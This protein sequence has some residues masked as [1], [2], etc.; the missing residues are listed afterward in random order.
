MRFAGQQS[1]GDSQRAVCVNGPA[2]PGEQHD[3]LNAETIEFVAKP[4]KAMEL[5]SAISD[6]VMP[7]LRERSGFINTILLTSQNEPR[8]LLAITFWKTSEDARQA[9]WEE[10]PLL[11]ELLAPLVDSCSRVRGFH[12]AGAQDHFDEQTEVV[13]LRLS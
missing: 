11:C 2:T 9:I 7:L 1:A 12:V 6:R 3:V 4:A 5:R 13:A 8:R 10:I